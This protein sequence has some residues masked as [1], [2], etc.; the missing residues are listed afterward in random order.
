M[1]LCYHKSCEDYTL[2]GFAYSTGKAEEFIGSLT[3]L[4]KTKDP[5]KLVPPTVPV[6]HYRL[7]F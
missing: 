6:R 7:R 5:A 2:P 4:R 3:I 1:S